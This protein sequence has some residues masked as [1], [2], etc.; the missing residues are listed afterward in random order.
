MTDTS[1]TRTLL[2][3]IPNLA[4]ELPQF[5]TATTPADTDNSGKPGPSESRPPLNVGLL[6]L[7]DGRDL[8]DWVTLAVDEMVEVDLEPEWTPSSR[9]A[10]HARIEP[11]C[12]WLTQHT[13]WIA[14]HNPDYQHA[15]ATLY[16]RYKH[17]ARQH[18]APNLKCAQCGNRAFIDSQ[19]LIC[20][21]V[22]TH[23]RTIKDIEH[24]HRYR[25]PIPAG[26]VA[27]EFGINLTKLRDWKRQGRIRDAG[28]QGRA[29]CYYPWDVFLLANP[30]IAEALEARDTVQAS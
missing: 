15:I 4:A 12:R 5:L 9:T 26:D 17:A 2:D 6:D 13:D 19:W 11:N 20:T 10:A 27:Q 1:Q 30:V 14:A 29:N 3:Q 18:P 25:P 8:D 22:E 7:I 23:A 24:E 28:N 16:G 21:E